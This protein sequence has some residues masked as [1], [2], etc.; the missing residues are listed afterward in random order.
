MPKNTNVTNENISTSNPG[1]IPMTCYGITKK[2]IGNNYLSDRD[3]SWKVWFHSVQMEIL[4]SCIML[5]RRIKIDYNSNCGLVFKKAVS[6]FGAYWYSSS[7]QRG[8]WMVRRTWLVLISYYHTQ[9][10]LTF[11][12][13]VLS[14]Y[15]ILFAFYSYLYYYL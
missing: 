8:H 6:G 9:L 4:G 2:T 5:L 10:L 7:Y 15:F 1:R 3:R 11:Y 12:I 14:L 13:F